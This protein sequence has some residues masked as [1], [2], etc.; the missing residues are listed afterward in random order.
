MVLPQL[1][2]TIGNAIISNTDLS[3]EYFPR[4]AG[5]VGVRATTVSQSAAN[6]VSFLMGGIPMCHGAGGLAAH[7]RFGARTAGSNTIIGLILILLAVIF[8]DSIVAVLGLL[9]LAI[10]GVLLAFA[11]LQ[12]ALM[13]HDLESRADYFVAVAM[14]GIGLTVNLG[15]AFL[16]GIIL[17]YLA[18]R[19]SVEL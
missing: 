3:H 6:I 1:P 2:M 11:G 9:P 4:N 8:G 17:A 18:H 14:L 15:V 7:Y 5:R 12:L 19:R 10:L 13:I 16:V